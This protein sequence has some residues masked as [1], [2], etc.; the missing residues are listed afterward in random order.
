[1]EKRG[2]LAEGVNAKQLAYGLGRGATMKIA[3]YWHD[4]KPPHEHENEE[5]G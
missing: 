2:L 4:K 3:Y 5:E 1:M